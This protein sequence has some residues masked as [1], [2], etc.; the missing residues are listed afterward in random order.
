[1][2]AMLQYTHHACTEGSTSLN[3][4]RA[5]KQTEA[6]RWRG[7]TGIGEHREPRPNEKRCLIA[8]P[9]GSFQV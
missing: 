2:C 6:Q 5:Q 4:S 3:T 1:M 9:Y 8:V 7:D